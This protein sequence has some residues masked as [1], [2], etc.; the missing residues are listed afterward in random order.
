MR[1]ERP[2]ERNVGLMREDL[3]LQRCGAN[4][5]KDR[6]DQHRHVY[7]SFH[8]ENSKTGGATEPVYS[9]NLHLSR[10][11]PLDR[12]ARAGGRFKPRWLHG[13]EN[14]QK[15]SANKRRKLGGRSFPNPALRNAR[16]LQSKALGRLQ[17]TDWL[18]LALAIVTVPVA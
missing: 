12:P 6:R 17:E 8:A 5:R 10:T 7:D 2:L 4:R 13:S 15:R 18:V 3:V 16:F 1:L 9:C 14:P 11:L